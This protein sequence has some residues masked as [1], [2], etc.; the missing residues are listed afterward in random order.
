[1]NKIELQGRL[2]VIV[3]ES[4]DNDLFICADIGGINIWDWLKSNKDK[5]VKITL[6]ELKEQG[7]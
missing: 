3:E 1:M 4:E 2:C 6:E 7:K 5:E